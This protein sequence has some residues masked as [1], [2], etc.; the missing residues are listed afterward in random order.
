M[1]YNGPITDPRHRYYMQLPGP[2][3]NK[4]PEGNE[5]YAKFRAQPVNLSRMNPTGP[6]LSNSHLYTKN[7]LLRRN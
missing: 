4:M 7:G 6:N 2:I 1:I 5:R 3:F